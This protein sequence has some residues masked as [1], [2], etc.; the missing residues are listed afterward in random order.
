MLFCLF[1]YLHGLFRQLLFFFL[2]IA[3][4]FQMYDSLD[5]FTHVP[6]QLGHIQSWYFWCKLLELSVLRP[7]W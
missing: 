6:Q 1:I 2:S 4:N 3:L 7:F 5:L